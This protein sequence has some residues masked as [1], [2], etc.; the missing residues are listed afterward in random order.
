MKVGACRDT[1]LVSI[2]FCLV[3][4]FNEACSFEL[5]ENNFSMEPSRHA[6]GSF[7]ADLL[8]C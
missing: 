1:F 2:S 5:L 4:F 3:T 8:I 6:R 7:P